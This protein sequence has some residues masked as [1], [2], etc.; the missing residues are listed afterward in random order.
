M[1]PTL[2]RFEIE[3]SVF[4]NAFFA[5]GFDEALDGLMSAREHS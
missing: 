5:G 3:C 1:A 2:Q 4:E